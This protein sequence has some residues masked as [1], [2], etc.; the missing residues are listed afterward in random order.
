MGDTDKPVSVTDTPSTDAPAAPATEPQVDPKSPEE[1]RKRIIEAKE[2]D[3]AA[4][5]PILD[6][7]GSTNAANPEAKPQEKDA[8]ES[9]L[10]LVKAATG[11]D[12]NSVVDAEKFLS[13]LHKLVGDQEVSDGRKAKELIVEWGKKQGKTYDEARQIMAD[14]LIDSVSPDAQQPAPVV[15]PKVEPEKVETKEPEKETPGKVDPR[16]TRLKKL[17][18]D[19]NKRELL[20]AYPESDEVIEQVQQIAEAMGLSWKV[21]YEQTPFKAILAE[22]KKVEAKNSPEVTPS[23]RTPQNRQKVQ[24]I[25]RRILN[26]TATDD[27]RVKLIEELGLDA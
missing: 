13:N 14:Q 5:A 22:R 25:G 26:N 11:R 27:D 18:D 10:A 24:D 1:V 19:N 2:Q 7:V 17:E 21:A 9:A 23:N 4:D 15:E 3:K 16:D 6:E 20:L 12:F 8:T